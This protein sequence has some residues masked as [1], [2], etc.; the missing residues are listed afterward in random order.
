MDRMRSLRAVVRRNN[1]YAW[2][3]AV[4]GAVAEVQRESAVDWEG[5]HLAIASGL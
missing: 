4:L 5:D 3:A 2:A 1:V